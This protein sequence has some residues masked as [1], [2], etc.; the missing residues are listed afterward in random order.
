LTEKP[1]I[2][3]SSLNDLM[4][5]LSITER[6][7][8]SCRKLQGHLEHL[9]IEHP[10]REIVLLNRR[11]S[12]F[13]K[14]IPDLV[15]DSFLDFMQEFKVIFY[16]ILM[17]TDNAKILSTTVEIDNLLSLMFWNVK[18]NRRKDPRYP[19]AIEGVM[20]NK[21]GV[22]NEILI[23]DISSRGMQLYSA[24]KPTIEEIYSIRFKTKKSYEL[25]F[26][27]LKIFDIQDMNSFKFVV[28]GQLE[29]ILMWD[30][31]REVLDFCYKP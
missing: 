31:I 11:I 30:D 6:L 9:L 27:P 16:F 7:F 25:E 5:A 15:D 23:S 2:T 18:E 21:N 13:I 22:P 24:N 1:F 8:Y 29:S 17:K 4:T 10:S 14:M 12:K 20:E 3:Q 28:T 19:V 26:I